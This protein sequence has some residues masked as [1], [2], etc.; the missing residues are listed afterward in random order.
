MLHMILD[1]HWI[2]KSC[3][4]AARGAMKLQGRTDMTRSHFRFYN[5]HR[6]FSRK[7]FLHGFSFDCPSDN[8]CI[9]FLPFIWNGLSF[10]EM[11]C[12][13]TFSLPSL[14]FNNRLNLL[15][16][17]NSTRITTH[18]DNWGTWRTGEVLDYLPVG[19][20]QW[21][22][23]SSRSIGCM[24]LRGRRRGLR[25]RRIEEQFNPG[26]ASFVAA[27]VLS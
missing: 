14:S 6:S 2:W 21:R 26:L 18:R 3:V 15:F 16:K 24:R 4:Q 7:S 23:W 19:L 1:S 22:M 13:C 17:H 5:F 9:L 27:H 10:F 8:C 20:P 12:S 11:V 25:S